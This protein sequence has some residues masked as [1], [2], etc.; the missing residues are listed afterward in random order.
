MKSIKES[1][2]YTWYVKT[3]KYKRVHAFRLGFSYN[4][5]SHPVWEG[6]RWVMS[7]IEIIIHLFNTD[8]H[9]F[10]RTMSDYKMSDKDQ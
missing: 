2:V 10:R 4:V 8:L 5:D 7:D 3:I 6:R 1:R 9:I